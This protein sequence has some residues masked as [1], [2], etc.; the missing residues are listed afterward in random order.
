MKLNKG[1]F[2][3]LGTPLDH[4]GRLVEES[5][6]RQIDMQINAGAAGALCMGSMGAEAALT[7][8][9]YARTAKT[10]AEAVAGRVPLFV[11]AMDN[12]V[13]RVKERF[14]ALADLPIDGVV[15]TTPFYSTTSTE[16]L[17]RFFLSAADAAPHPLYLYDLPGVTKQKITFSMVKAL[18]KHPNIRGIKTGDIVLARK[19]QLECPEFDLL[20]SNIDIFDVANAFALPRVLDGM[21][22]C[23]PANTAAF[24]DCFLAGDFA[25]AG[26]H[27]D[28]ILALRDLFLENGVWPGFTVAMNLLGLDG[29]YGF[30]YDWIPA[31]GEAER[32]EEFMKTIGEI[33]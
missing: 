9:E 6:R 21:F 16:N 17:I 7:T 28:N 33:H 13:F 32:V 26:K 15:L 1:F 18:A 10:A 4:E 3:A 12:S 31:P 19:L 25:G 14:A 8:A 29:N 20:F 30:G 27:L 5:L 23:T 2:P 22:A 24:N 11:G